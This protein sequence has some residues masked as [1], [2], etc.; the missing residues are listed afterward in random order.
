VKTWS[1]ES[2]KGINIEEEEEETK[3]VG[4]T[5]RAKIFYFV[6]VVVLVTYIG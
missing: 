2:V 1:T 6:V 5:G 3:F 4:P